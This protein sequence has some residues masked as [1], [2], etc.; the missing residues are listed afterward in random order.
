VLVV[1]NRAKRTYVEEEVEAL[2]TTAMVVLAVDDRLGELSALAGSRRRAGPA[3]SFGCT[4]P[5]RSCPIGIA[6]GHVG[7]C[8]SRASSSPITSPRTCAKELKRLDTALVR[9]CAPTST[10]CWSAATSPKAASTGDVLE[11]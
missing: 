1:Q 10:A 11:A 3:R 2:Q 8:T 6:L 5:A 4:R 7:V 9:N